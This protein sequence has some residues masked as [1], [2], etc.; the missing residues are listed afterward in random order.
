MR[1]VLAIVFVIGCNGNAPPP[2]STTKPQQPPTTAPPRT[3]P[4]PTVAPQSAVA[5]YS[6]GCETEC[7]DDLA[8]LVTYRDAKGAI[9]IVTVQ[10]S[11][12]RCSHPPLRFLGPDGTERVVIPLKPVVPGSAEAKQFDEI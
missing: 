1:D 3:S 6:K 10:G 5:G 4:P 8:E 12:A 11:P 9:A 7:A 2:S